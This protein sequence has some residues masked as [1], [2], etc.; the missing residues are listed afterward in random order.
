MANYYYF[1]FLWHKWNNNCINSLQRTTKLSDQRPLERKRKVTRKKQNPKP[2]ASEDPKKPQAK[3]PLL[4]CWCCQ[5]IERPTLV[6]TRSLVA[7]VSS[8]L[9]RNLHVDAGYSLLHVW[10]CF[11]AALAWS[12][13]TSQRMKEISWAVEMWGP[14]GWYHFYVVPMWG[15][16][17][18]NLH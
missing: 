2:P 8:N 4:R 7:Q 9:M 13:R 12:W 17:T 18:S 14:R 5:E 10:K 15:P 3:K 16:L 11:H 6:H 1:L